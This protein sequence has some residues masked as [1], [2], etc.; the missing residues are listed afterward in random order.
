MPSKKRS[1]KGRGFKGQTRTDDLFD[2]SE[3]TLFAALVQSVERVL[4]RV[5]PVGYDEHLLDFA[6]KRLQSTATRREDMKGDELTLHQSRMF[7]RRRAMVIAIGAEIARVAGR[8]TRLQC[9]ETISAG[10]MKMLGVL[11]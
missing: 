2:N 10:V 9:K 7:E 5:C 8:Q 3:Q 11:D 1:K 6:L 4:E